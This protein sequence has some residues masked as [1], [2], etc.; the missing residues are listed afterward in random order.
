MG[1][2]AQSVRAGRLKAPGWEGFPQGLVRA[3]SYLTA[4]GKRILNLAF[5][6]C[7]RK[8]GASSSVG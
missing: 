8:N 7:L 5:F 2:V 1:P 4:E 3:D 6:I